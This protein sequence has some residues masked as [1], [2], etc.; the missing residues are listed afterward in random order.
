MQRTLVAA[1]IA[2]AAA[3]SAGTAT[4]PASARTLDP[5]AAGLY[6]VV[7]RQAPVASYAGGMPALAATRPATGERFD[8]TRRVVA[9]YRD[10]LV[11]RQSALLA[12]I[13]HPEVVYSYTTALDGFA[14][15]LTPTQVQALSV[16]PDV[17]RVQADSVRAVDEID[18][19]GAA[20]ARRLRQA[21]ATGRQQPAS[22]GP[23]DG[24]GVVVGVVD[25]GVWPENPSLAGNPIGPRAR[26]RAYPGF[27]GTCER[28]ESW[29]ARTCTAKVVAARSF[30]EGFGR[31]NVAQS[32]FRS[33]RDVTGHGTGVAAVAAG[34]P[35]VDARIAG[36]DFGHI[37]GAAP[38][39]A[40]SV[41]KACWTAPDPADDGCDVADTVAA[42]DQAVQDGVDVL[43]YSVSGGTDPYDAVE[44]AFLHATAANVVVAASAGNGGPSPGSVRHASPW[45]ATVG[46]NRDR[47][48]AGS[49][50]LGDGTVLTGATLS[51][52]RVPA[53]RLVY[54]ADA[55][56]AGVPRRSAAR[57][58]AGSL[59][60]RSVEG[61]VVLCDRG[62]TPRVG[63]SMTVDQSGGAAML[64]VNTRPG[65]VDADLHSVPTVHLAVAAG[66][67][68]KAYLADAGTA[69]TAA[70][71]PAPRLAAA[72]R[73]TASFSG[74]GPAPAWGGEVL[75]PDLTAPGL[76]V[77]TAT[78]PISP[79]S[80]GLLWDVVSGT[81]LAAPRVAGTAGVL[82]AAH[83]S[84]SPAAILSAMTTTASTPTGPT[85]ALVRGAGELAPSRALT[86]GLVY[87][88]A[89]GSWA[90]LLDDRLDPSDA[91]LASISVGDLVAQQ[92]IRRTVAN[93][94]Q[95]TGTYTASVRGLRGVATSVSP[96]VLV[97]APGRTASYTVTFTATRDATY[98]AFT[99]GALTWRS[100]SGTTVTSPIAVRPQLARVP[101]EV[102]G[103]ASAARR[104]GA[105]AIRAEAGVTGTIRVSSPGLVGATPVPLIVRSAPERRTVEVPTGSRAVRFQVTSP[106]SGADLVVHVYRA[107]VLA[108]EAADVT[109][110]IT[111][112]VTGG[113]AVDGS[114]STVT[115]RDP[116]PGTYT[117]SVAAGAGQGAGRTRVALTSWVLPAAAKSRLEIER[118]SIGVTGG[119]PF[120]VV[121]RWSGLDP[122]QRWWGIVS[123]RGL[124]DVTYVTID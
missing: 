87:D 77:L 123:Y 119:E 49:V 80:K 5:D 27:T 71:I 98:D 73:A 100:R 84:W 124:P 61:A 110:D 91:N 95:Q 85:R 102:S 83:P 4:L 63:K 51:D 107:G 55:A 97:V 7:L 16:S 6:L 68:V 106:D 45:V 11:A 22:G 88:A 21:T 66:R 78:S 47:V 113:E 120:T 52:S 59:D 13:G 56:A 58:F 54:A 53:T 31:S 81:S 104:G 2:V 93:V 25:T 12:R 62:T 117:I 14:A 38:A 36:Q 114:S 69:A 35:G 121:A 50:R 101:G 112:G 41:Y 23:D 60:A 37:S 3:M 94:E 40:L 89:P 20:A 118:P 74:R 9:E 24:R 82:R 17:V 1:V 105:L 64:L 70:L 86:P 109:G 67:A 15:R 72:D 103:E 99:T 30:V 116:V 111:G 34:N 115:L 32:D 29:N 96:R 19:S 8:D 44:L 108:D 65:T 43:S 76:D 92:T 42:I 90:A 33:P 39:A 57:C 122:A 18:P 48:Y 79:S 75:E 26:Q 10:F 46:A 28:G